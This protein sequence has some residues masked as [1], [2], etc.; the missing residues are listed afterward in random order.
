MVAVPP[1]AEHPTPLAE[2]ERG[3]FPKCLHFFFAM[4]A[5]QG[6][7]VPFWVMVRTKQ[8][9][10][11]REKGGKVLIEMLA[12]PTVVNSMALRGIQQHCEGA[13]VKSDV[14][15]NKHYPRRKNRARDNAL[16]GIQF[17]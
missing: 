3:S 4:H 13:Q 12:H 14:G 9:I 16:L 1:C 15:V 17:E 5:G 2:R 11:N 10:P 8:D 7:F 6:I